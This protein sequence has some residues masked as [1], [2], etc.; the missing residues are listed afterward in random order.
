MEHAAT[1]GADV[2]EVKAFAQELSTAF[3]L[4]RELQHNWKPFSAWWD[5]E[6]HN[7]ARSIRC[8]R[9]KTKK[10]QRLSSAGAVLSSH[11]EYADGYLAQHLGRIVG[12]AR[13]TLRLE[14]LIRSLDG[15]S[16]AIRVAGVSN[17]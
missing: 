8:M 12:E 9:C 7:Y 15:H 1:E 6:H 16:P 13:D 3:L 17:N 11:Y 4:C 10:V 5:D 2:E 14:S